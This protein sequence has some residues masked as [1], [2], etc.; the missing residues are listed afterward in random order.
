MQQSAKTGAADVLDIEFSLA[1]HNRTGK[2][3]I[4][5]DLLQ[6][7]ADQ[8]GAIW[9]WRARRERL[10]EGLDARIIGRALAIEL[11]FRERSSR[12]DRTFARIRSPRPVLHLDPFTAPAHRLLPSDA[13]LCHDMG[14]ITHPDLFMPDVAL[15]YVRVFDEI[16]KGGPH[17]IFVSRAS[18]DAFHALYGEAY[19][20]SRVI[21]PSIRT[22]LDLT[23]DMRPASDIVEPFLLMVGSV[24]ARKNQLRVVRAFE[25][26]GLAARGFQ[27]VICGGWEPGYEAVAAAAAGVANV[28]LMGYADDAVLNW[29]YAHASGF[30]LPSLLEGFGIPVAEAIRKGLV[31]LIARGT[32]LEEVAGVGAV[33]V[34]A[35]DEGEI[36]EGL[37]TLA[38]MPM[39]EKHRRVASMTR[40]LPRFSREG[41]RSGWARAFEEILGARQSP[42]LRPER[43][44]GVRQG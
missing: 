35:L 12:F 21:Y 43:L 7:Q 19:R 30:V 22:E 1:L 4:G 6:D 36:A 3:F 29:L 17:M 32:V 20:S 27:L 34:D 38:L 5:R 9:Y 14:P 41:F 42:S 33:A 37:K 16:R 44:E 11:Q 18:Q 26:S 15:A 31:P 23:Q 2:Y 40:S 39:E 28:R 10:P 13:V 25:R 8:I 24:G